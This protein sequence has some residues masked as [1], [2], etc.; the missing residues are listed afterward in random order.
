MPTVRRAERTQTLNELRGGERRAAETALSQGAGVE[1]ARIEKLGALGNVADRMA[2]MGIAVYRNLREAEVDA[3]NN[4]AALRASNQ[5]SD[6]KNKRLYD[7]NRG[8]LTLKG[9]AAMPLPEEIAAEFD[10][11]ASGIEASLSTPEQRAAF[12]RMRS[13]EWQGID[14]TV[15]RHVAGEVQAYRAQELTAHVANSVNA[16]IASA[17]DPKL[18]QVELTKAVTAIEK[19]APAL[20]LGKEA[21]D[22]QVRDV[23]TKT[24]LGVISQLLAQEND[25]A[26]T[27]YFHAT[28]GQIAGEKL[29]EVERAIA[30]GTL[31]GEGQRRSDA[32]I[33]KGKPY[34]DQLEEA[35]QIDDPKVRDAVEQRLEHRKQIEDRQVAEQKVEHQ[36]AGYDILDK[37]AD[38][39]KIPAAMWTSYDG[40]TRS[41]ME[42][43]ARAKRKGDPIETDNPTYY[44]LMQQ[45]GDDPATFATQVNLLEFRHKLDDGDFKQLAT[46][47]LSIKSGDRRA[48]EKEVAE[49]QTRSQLLDDTLINHGID[50]KAKF[51]TPQG[52]AIAQLRR[53]VD[54]RVGLLQAA[55]KKASNQDIQAEI[56][57]LLSVQTET[58]GSWWNIFPGGKAGPWGVDQKRAIDITVNDIS[59]LERTQI[60]EALRAKNRPV[61]DATVLDLYIEDKVRR[62]RGGK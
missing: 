4:T 18:V 28:R 60:E 19:N 5:L 22:Q 59:A 43:Y 27:A 42:S 17:L 1:H 58:P 49:F 62:S 25:K 48:G 51:D 20:G 12:Q 9:E 30:E 53:M 44:K 11:V 56:D 32:I 41:A 21:I 29:D 61:S 13:Q 31:R 23:T 2:H 54:N 38:T 7:P 52:K 8:A 34:K 50:P 39:S 37:T 55:G 46:L 3:A 36:R 16:A 14:L 33:A 24:H 35:R 47:Q 10:Q 45:A 26:A 6:W 40:G 57:S 15:R